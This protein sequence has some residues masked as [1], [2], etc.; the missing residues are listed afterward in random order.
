M[1]DMRPPKMKPSV[2]TY[3]KGLIAGVAFG[4]SAAFMTVVGI[5]VW[6]KPEIEEKVKSFCETIL[7]AA[8]DSCRVGAQ[9]GAC[10]EPVVGN[11]GG[12]LTDPH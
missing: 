12:N 7:P 1:E 6:L 5:S 8:D 4:M 3:A 10:V 9:D 2:F 11:H